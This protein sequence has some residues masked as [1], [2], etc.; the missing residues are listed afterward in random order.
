MSNRSSLSRW[1]VP[2][3][4]IVALACSE[5]SNDS[6]GALAPNGPGTVAPSDGL[7]GAGG[8]GVT[9]PGNGTPGSGGSGQI[10]PGAAGAGITPGAVGS[11]GQ[12]G[13]G[14][15]LAPGVA[16]TPGNGGSPARGAGGGPAAPGMP[17]NGGTAPNLGST[18][19]T[20]PSENAG[21][22]ALAPD[23]DAG[24]PVTPIDTAPDDYTQ[25]LTDQAV[26]DEAAFDPTAVIANPTDLQ[27]LRRAVRF[28]GAERCGDTGNWLIQDHALGGT[29]HLQDG[30]DVGLDLSG[31]WHDA[32]DHVKVTLTIGYAAYSLLKTFAAFP[33]V[34]V[35]VE[36]PN[37]DG[38]PNG[39]PD[40]LDEA[41]V[42]LDW[43]VKAHPDPDTF[44]AMVANPDQD[45]KY[46]YTSPYQ[47]TLPTED[48]GDPRVTYPDAAAD[49][50]G[51]AAA[52]LALG[53][54]VY[55]PYDSDLADLYLSK[56]ETALAYAEAHPGESDS[57][58]YVWD[59]VTW[60]DDILAA[61]AE[62]YRATG[63]DEYLQTALSYNDEIGQ[64]GW[65][66]SYGQV[67]DLGRHTL[68]EL[69]QMAALEPWQ[70]DVDSYIDKI[71]EEDDPETGTLFVPAVTRAMKDNLLGLTY[72]DMW[73]TCRYGAAAGFSAAL[74]AQVTGDATYRD[75]ALSQYDWIQGDNPHGRS[76]IVGMGTNPP[77]RPHHRNAFGHDDTEGFE[78][79]SNPAI[80][81]TLP[82][83]HI[84]HGAL[85]GG[86]SDEGYVDTIN[87]YRDN[88]VA[89][90]YNAGLVGL[91]AYALELAR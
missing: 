27:I 62:L 20:S 88:E 17:G 4:A 49:F 75:Y 44:I 64:T 13:V 69:G 35:D 65:V 18:P 7:P 86:P 14:S 45:H 52:A 55:R 56:A 37:Y 3:S 30:A 89:L 77:L 31:G 54:V 36:G 38:V 25:Q 26:Q 72:F 50:V 61:S 1:L 60:E 73:G 81:N 43:L 53:S 11:P 76:F 67:A 12:S 29:C 82:Y 8:R 48:G 33:Q 2:F 15:N 28:Y 16:G 41:R 83:A 87:D 58:L 59:G 70:A 23:F 46:F 68:V 71:V 10:A 19:S 57:P 78:D 22:P 84:L 40:V 51:V 80:D 5:S 47:S 6:N 34:F 74:L 32:G 21:A 42:G 66:L 24:A 85:V 91:A 63:R 9:S 90:D 79:P 39:V